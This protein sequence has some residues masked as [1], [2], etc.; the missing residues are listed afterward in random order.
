M[1]NSLIGLGP[2]LN[3]CLVSPN[4]ISFL[5]DQAVLLKRTHPINMSPWLWHR[6]VKST[7]RSRG[8]WTTSRNKKAGLWPLRMTPWHCYQ[9]QRLRRSKSR[10]WLKN[11]TDPWVE[12]VLLPQRSRS[13]GESVQEAPSSGST[14]RRGRAALRRAQ[15]RV[16]SSLHYSCYFLGFSRMLRNFP[17]V[18]S[19]AGITNKWDI[20]K[21]PHHLKKRS[22]KD[23]T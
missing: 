7:G 19:L 10:G 11:C 3:G 23:L 16:P 21:H 4:S 5:R 1:E 2:E 22:Q 17:R 9:R 12:Q 20:D 15:V 8:S 18:I 14:G 6:W 13:K